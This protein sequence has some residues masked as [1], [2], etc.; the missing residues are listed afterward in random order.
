MTG[1]PRQLIAGGLG[2]DQADAVV[3]AFARH[4]GLVERERRHEGGWTAL[5]LTP[6]D[7]RPARPPRTLS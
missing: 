3:A 2:P 1:R 4:Q 7:A 5:L 6:A